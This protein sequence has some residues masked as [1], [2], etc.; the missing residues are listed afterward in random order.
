MRN[1]KKNTHK[2]GNPKQVDKLMRDLE[3]SRTTKIVYEFHPTIRRL[4][5]P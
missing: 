2:R 4:S 5:K 3:N 1:V